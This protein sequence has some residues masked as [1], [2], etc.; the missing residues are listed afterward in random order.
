MRRCLLENRARYHRSGVELRIS[1]AARRIA[2]VTCL[3]CEHFI[4]FVRKQYTNWLLLTGLCLVA[5]I[6]T[7]VKY[8]RN[9]LLPICS[10]TDTAVQTHE[11][12]LRSLHN[13]LFRKAQQ[14]EQ[15]YERKEHLHLVNYH[16][17]YNCGTSFILNISIL[18]SHTKQW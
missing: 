14:R 6:L 8:Y 9:C 7:F 5:N 15:K 16:A 17:K 3:L 4:R 2:L 11:S 12:C 13:Q 10:A 1:G 18:S